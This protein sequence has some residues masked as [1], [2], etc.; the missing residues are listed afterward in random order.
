M[1]HGIS[2]FADRI[3]PVATAKSRAPEEV[4][5]EEVA[6][7]E[8]SMSSDLEK[9]FKELTA[10]VDNKGNPNINEL[11]RL[12]KDIDLIKLNI[13]FFGYEIARQLAAALPPRQGL[14]PTNVGLK[15]KASTQSDLESD[16]V[17]Y[18]ASELK[19]PVVFHRKLWELAYVLQ[20]LW[21]H[22][23][24][25]SEK[26]GLGFGC[27]VEPIPSY[28]ASHDVAVT[29]TDLPPEHGAKTGWHDSNQYTATLEH[30]Y[31]AE[32]VD[33]DRFKKYVSLNFVD[34][35]A[36]PATLRDYDFCWSICALEHIGSIKLGLAFIENSLNT[37]R[38]GG[39]AIH[40]TE[41]NYANDNA[42]IDNWGTVLF[43][44]QHF[45][46]LAERL[47]GSGHHVAP[48]DFSVGEKVL[49]RFIDLPPYS[50]DMTSFQ[51]AHWGRD[52][53][54]IKAAVDGFA[55]TCFGLIIKKA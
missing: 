35:N 4:S 16:W 1:G 24:L 40:T 13:K 39:L 29:V 25:E 53:N 34:M 5:Q 46:Q 31:K 7:E 9:R 41:Y 49:D 2:S 6:Q 45:N 14:A 26:R 27:G 37:L 47:R 51:Q 23:C 32:L 17:A 43:Q 20:A 28:L 10:L 22:G 3:K 19:V 50:H 55:S 11:W 18:W 44:R 30:A 38:V 12:A 21:E 36:I 54:H 52:S 42:T 8:V 15:S 33:R 48:L